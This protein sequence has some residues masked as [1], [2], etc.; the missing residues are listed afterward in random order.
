MKNQILL[1]IKISL[2]RTEETGKI[3]Y[4]ILN[5]IESLR[6]FLK[7]VKDKWLN[8]QDSDGFYFY[9]AV[10][11]VEL[12]LGEMERGFE[13]ARKTDNGQKIAADAMSLLPVIDRILDMA[14]CMKIST[15]FIDQVLDTTQ[16]L[17]TMASDVD[18]IEPLDISRKVLD[19]SSIKV[20]FSTLMQ[21]LDAWFLQDTV[22]S[23]SKK[24][25]QFQAPYT[26]NSNSKYEN[27][28][29]LF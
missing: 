23:Y 17:R 20:Q 22:K 8:V 10:R 9:Q 29:V 3:D 18:L 5:N 25:V 13:N 24:H 21:K 4:M 14:Q 12:I 6:E 19:K 28:Q 2:E 26:L 11:N 16:A 1:E 27:M 15:Y 7:T